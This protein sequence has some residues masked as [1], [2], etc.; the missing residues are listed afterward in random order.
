MD[1]ELTYSVKI[2]N[3][4]AG[5]QHVLHQLTGIEVSLF[6]SQ[7]WEDIVENVVALQQSAGHM[8]SYRLQG[9]TQTMFDEAASPAATRC[10][11]FSGNTMMK[12]KGNIPTIYNWLIAPPT[13]SNMSDLSVRDGDS[14]RRSEEIVK[15]FESCLWMLLLLLLPLACICLWKQNTIEDLYDTGTDCTITQCE[16]TAQQ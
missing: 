1:K 12:L 13:D 9:P 16:C 6:V 11:T 7:Q 8:L 3:I 15:F 5:L 10:V 4:S 14:S 2:Q